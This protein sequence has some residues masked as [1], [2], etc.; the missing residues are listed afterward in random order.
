MT[1]ADTP[2][3]QHGLTLF[4]V[5]GAIWVA[6]LFPIQFIH[7]RMACDFENGGVISARYWALSRHWFIWGTIATVLPLINIYVMVHKS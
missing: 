1:V 6:I 3:V 7:T 2:L 5:S 4:R